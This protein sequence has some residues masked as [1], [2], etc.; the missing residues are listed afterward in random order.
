[1]YG[2]QCVERNSVC[3]EIVTANSAL[4][5]RRSFSSNVFAGDSQ[6]VFC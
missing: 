5:R 1:M 6:A 2:L 3:A 4:L